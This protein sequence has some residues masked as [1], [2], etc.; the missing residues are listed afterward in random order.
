MTKLKRLIL[1]FVPML[2]FSGCR[3]TTSY[4]VLILD[5]AKEV[6][7][8]WGYIP[9]R[10]YS[11]DFDGSIYTVDINGNQQQIM[12]PESNENS[13]KIE[14]KN[15][16]KEEI[17]T[18]L[19]AIVEESKELVYSY[20]ETSEILQNKPDIVNY[21][22]DMQAYIVEMD[23][24]AMYED[25]AVYISKQYTY[26]ASEWMIVHELIHAVC[27]F[28]NGG[29][30][31]QRYPYNLFN[32]VMTDIITSSMNPSSA[33]GT[34]SGY[35]MYYDIGYAFI[36]CFGEKA[37]SSYFYGY[38]SLVEELGDELDLFVFSM[39]NMEKNEIAL[40][41]VNNSINHW[42]ENR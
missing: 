16:V 36:G 29:V 42:Q 15:L 11:V 33:E 32:E 4:D 1:I 26:A 24:V 6:I 18:E 35:V 30:E 27:D 8:Q 34:M 5:N 37:L 25:G 39:E 20:I 22:S 40:I 41:C 12:V 23:D 38:D 21:I 9:N 31:N 13:G 28:T 10:T 3:N 2:L 19:A 14:A 17:S 7:E